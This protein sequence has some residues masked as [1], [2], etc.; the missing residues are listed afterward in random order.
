MIVKVTWKVVVKL[1]PTTVISFFIYV[2]VGYT[3]YVLKII[4]LLFQNAVLTL[5]KFKST[6]KYR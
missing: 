3:A 5:N 4:Y 1:V 2:Y 6:G